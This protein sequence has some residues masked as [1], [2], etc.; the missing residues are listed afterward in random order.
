MTR[1]QVLY[2]GSGAAAAAVAGGT[3]WLWTRSASGAPGAVLWRT[4]AHPDWGLIAGGG[5]VYVLGGR[6]SAASGRTGKPLWQA[7]Q[8]G[9]SG[10]AGSGVV[11]T[12]ALQ[13]T[14]VSADAVSY[15]AFSAGDGRVLWTYNGDGQHEIGGFAYGGGASYFADQQAG[16]IALDAVTGQRRWAAPV[17]GVAAAL[18]VGDDV[19][20]LAELASAGA[21]TGR[22]WAMAAADG[23]LV[24]DSPQVPMSAAGMVL[25]AGTGAVCGG[26]RGQMFALDPGTGQLRWQASA[27][28]W[29][30]F[31]LAGGT[32]LLMPGAARSGHVLPALSA[33]SGRPAWQRELTG[34][35]L[36]AATCNQTFLVACADGTLYAIAASTGH[37]RW[38]YRLP[39]APAGLAADPAS[40]TAYAAD[41]TG[42]MYALRI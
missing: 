9:F 24:W 37:V 34:K 41:S 39:S 35:P 31:A 29:Y 6:L 1:R 33:S 40:G 17:Q 21:G 10:A 15:T 5:V 23:T 38:Q 27:R 14:A 30:P 2:A 42:T 22:V 25:V 36:L 18:A 12:A 13:A 3:G 16:L 8:A 4:R 20:Y 26:D 7:R 28:S 19:V 32:V 11:I